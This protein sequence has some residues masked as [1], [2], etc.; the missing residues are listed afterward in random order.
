MF[1]IA[2][3]RLRIDGSIGGSD[4]SFR[5]LEDAFDAFETVLDMLSSQRPHR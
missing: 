5:L 2:S 4:I 3:R 1:V